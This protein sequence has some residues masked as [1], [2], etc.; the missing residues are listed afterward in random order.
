MWVNH[1]NKTQKSMRSTTVVPCENRY[2]F[3]SYPCCHSTTL[4]FHHAVGAVPHPM[5][6]GSTNK[7]RRAQVKTTCAVC[8]TVAS[9]SAACCSDMVSMR[10]RMVCTV[11]CV[12]IMSCVIQPPSFLIIWCMVDN[13]Q[14]NSHPVSTK[15]TK[16]L[17]EHFVL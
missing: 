7:S 6:K 5:D 14:P 13:T 11:T 12:G 15:E 1:T 3:A 2:W 16:K 17:R 8:I 4:R 10:K 9:I